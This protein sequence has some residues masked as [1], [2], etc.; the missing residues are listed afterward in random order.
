MGNPADTR[1][2]AAIR[3]YDGSRNASRFVLLDT[4]VQDGLSLLFEPG[5]GCI[6]VFGAGYESR[7]NADAWQNDGN[8]TDASHDKM[9]LH[10]PFDC[11]L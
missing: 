6:I 10:L 3:K 2:D 4:L 7:K 1:P 5:V 11:R 8:Q 9:S